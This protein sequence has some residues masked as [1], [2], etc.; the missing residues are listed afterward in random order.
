MLTK[1]KSGKLDQSTLPPVLIK[2][3][4]ANEGLKVASYTAEDILE[5]A[6]KNAKPELEP[7]QNTPSEPIQEREQGPEAPIT[8]QQPTPEVVAPDEDYDEDK[9]EEEERERGLEGQEEDA[10]LGRIAQRVAADLNEDK[11]D[12]DG[13][14]VLTHDTLDPILLEEIKGEGLLAGVRDPA[15]P[16]PP[17]D[18]NDAPAATR[19]SIETDDVDLDNGPRNDNPP[20]QYGTGH[21]LVDKTPKSRRKPGR[22]GQD[23]RI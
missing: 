15:R 18:L 22:G 20:K 5:I 11:D 23:M 21:G 16:S 9:P 10:I 7:N 14:A 12:N 6:G 17:L 4:Q 8:E 3:A 13:I 2:A 19:P 1:V